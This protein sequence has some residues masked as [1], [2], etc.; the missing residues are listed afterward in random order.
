MF[1]IQMNSQIQIT[2]KVLRFENE[3]NNFGH[4]DYSYFKM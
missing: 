2:I 4:S 3:Y 1:P